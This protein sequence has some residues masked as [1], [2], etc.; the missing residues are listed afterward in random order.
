MSKST[1]LKTAMLLEQNIERKVQSEMEGSSD[2]SGS[3]GHWNWPRLFSIFIFNLGMMWYTVEPYN[4]DTPGWT[5]HWEQDMKTMEILSIITINLLYGYQ[6]KTESHLFYHADLATFV[7]ISLLR[8]QS[9]V[10]AHRL[11]IY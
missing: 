9:H 8:Y 6:G 7:L 10:V 5:E 11:K 1:L 4:S 3:Q 2:K